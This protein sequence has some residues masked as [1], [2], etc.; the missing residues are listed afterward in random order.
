LAITKLKA[1]SDAA[2]WAWSSAPGKKS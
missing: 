2:A 1:S